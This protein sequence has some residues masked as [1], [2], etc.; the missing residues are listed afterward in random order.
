MLAHVGE[1]DAAQRLEGAIEDVVAE[2]VSVTY[3]MKPEPDDP[4][5]VGT[6]GVADAIV[7]KLGA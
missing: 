3:D 4:T 5:A 2:G 6:S 7:K 1:T